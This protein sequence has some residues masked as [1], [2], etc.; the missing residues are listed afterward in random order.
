MKQIKKIYPAYLWELAYEEGRLNNS[1]S[2]VET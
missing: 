2:A 1:L